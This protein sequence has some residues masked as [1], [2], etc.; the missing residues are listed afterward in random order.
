MGT[1][2]YD[3]DIKRR[4]MRGHIDRSTANGMDR[5]APFDSGF[6]WWPVVVIALGLMAFIVAMS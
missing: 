5:F 4:I 3:T 2:N 1:D 6:P